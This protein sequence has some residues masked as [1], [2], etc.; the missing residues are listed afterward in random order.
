MV[1]L[2]SLFLSGIFLFF[3]LEAVYAKIW[4][5]PFLTYT[6]IFLQTPLTSDIEFIHK[7]FPFY[8]KLS[9]RKQKIFGHRLV[10]FIKSK[11]FISRGGVPI[12][13]EMK[14]L[15]GGTAIMLTFGMRKY[16]MPSVK[17]FVIYPSQYESVISRA[18]HLGEFNP[19]LK[20]IAFSWRDFMNGHKVAH[21]NLNLGIHEMAHALSYESLRLNHISAVLFADGLYKI[22][23][24]L[25]N[26]AFIS[27]LERS[28]YL[29]PYARVNKY[30]FFA[31]AL[32]H[33]I[34]TPYDF[35]QQYPELYRILHEMLNYKFEKPHF[36]V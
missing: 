31:V 23:M 6:H 27:R 9:P 28:S 7:N 13:R 32:E 2:L 18:E 20:T 34:E 24:L 4:R 8:E 12:T 11:E 15:I 26:N 16:S 1:I 30:E 5:K 29:R 14:L 33:F 19:G 22:D 10:R 17:R 3:F 35:H 25:K 36:S 21:D